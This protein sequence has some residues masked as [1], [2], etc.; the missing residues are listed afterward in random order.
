VGVGAGVTPKHDDVSSSTLKHTHAHDDG[1]STD[2]ESE[3]STQPR[4]EVLLDVRVGNNT[5]GSTDTPGACVRA[6]V[7]VC[8]CMHVRVCCV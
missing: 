2:D 7:C 5:P 1:D 6:C 8:D 3:D 4:R